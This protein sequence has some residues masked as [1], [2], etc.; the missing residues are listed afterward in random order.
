MKHISGLKRRK[1]KDQNSEKC[2]ICVMIRELIWRNKNAYFPLQPHKSEDR[3]QLLEVTL[4]YISI[5]RLKC[6][7]LVDALTNL[8]D[9]EE[10]HSELLWICADGRDSPIPYGPPRVYKLHC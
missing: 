4:P 9:P 5:L 7:P 8:S 10:V 3:V 6:Q 2:P 1:K